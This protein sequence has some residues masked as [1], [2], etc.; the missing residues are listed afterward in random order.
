MYMKLKICGLTVLPPDINESQIEFSAIDSTI[1]FGLRGIKNVGLAALDTII[2]ERQTGPFNDMLD[3]CKRLD[4]RTCNKRVVE[5]LICSGALDSLPGNRAQKFEELS[6]IIDYALEKK[7]AE[8]TGQLGLF[9]A[10]KTTAINE[11]IHLFQARAEWSDS[12]KLEKEKEVLGLYI[13]AQ[14]LDRF[15]KHLKWVQ[16]MPLKQVSQEPEGSF[17]ICGGSI[18]ASKIVTTKKGDSMAFLTL[19]DYSGKAE[20]VIFPKLF[21]QLEPWLASYQVFVIKGITDTASGPMA[22]IKA[23]SCIPLELLFEQS[24]SEKLV[25]TLPESFAE[26]NLSEL[27]NQ[28]V[29]G[30]T[31]I[32]IHFKE[33]EK[34][35]RLIARDKIRIT[36]SSLKLIEDLN[37]GIHLIL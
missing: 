18:K 13:S 28:L 30:S 2:A 3:F 15:T 25:L 23:Q 7:K 29:L 14:P 36:E 10:S 4:L 35:L 19:E 32:E 21:V 31:P 12:I 16:A 8:K 17:V 26:K 22:K 1:R 9:Q 6:K 33:H 27:K 11:E 34:L 5:S 37:I 24:F 20:A